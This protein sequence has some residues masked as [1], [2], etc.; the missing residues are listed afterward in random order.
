MSATDDARQRL[1]DADWELL[2]RIRFMEAQ[3]ANL[4]QRVLRLENEEQR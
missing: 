3:I 1:L 4:Q 2:S